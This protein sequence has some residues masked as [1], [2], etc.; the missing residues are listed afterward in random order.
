MKRAGILSVA[1]AAATAV[2]LVLAA[3]VV[4]FDRPGRAEAALPSDPGIIA[5]QSRTNPPENSNPEGDAEIFAMNPDGSGTGQLTVN[6]ANDTEPSLSADGSKI[7]FVS[8]RDGNPEIY[9]MNSDGSGQKRLT[10][11]AANDSDPT[12]SPD[13]KKVFFA[14]DREG[15]PEIYK[16]N[17]DGSGTPKNLTNNAASDV[18]P[19]V[20]PDGE[21][22]AFATL[23]DST[24]SYGWEIYVMRPDGSGQMMLTDNPATNGDS[25]P[26]FSADG[27]KIV[28]RSPPDIYVMGADGSD[29]N[30]LTEGEGTPSVWREDIFIGSPSF[31]T[32]GTRIAFHTA[33]EFLDRN[34]GP[35][36]DIFSMKS[37]G[38]GQ[39]QIT[40]DGV[41]SPGGVS[42]GSLEPDWQP[43]S[44]PAV[45]PLSPVPG[46]STTDRTP[47]VSARVKDAQEDLAN[48]DI[49]EL[50]L[51]GQTVERTAFSYDPSTDRLSY[52]PAGKLTYGR[53]TVRT[54]VKDSAG[55]TTTKGW[56]FRVVRP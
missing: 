35:Q 21:K 6:A 36:Y 8:V 49:T 10:D 19:A 15:N 30:N 41:N 44:S 31:S 12:F 1:T 46:S 52:T 48:Y 23:R 28:F 2:A 39:T 54:V 7:T 29:R 32:D 4:A 43:N 9:K 38:S 3:A 53:H 45:K 34:G 13:G 22:I 47:Y 14:S 42:G 40:Q 17:A 37:D 5:F 55:A 11:N 51:D 25:S 20:S 27:K 26:D 18:Q 56:S 33:T 50:S 24:S 16:M